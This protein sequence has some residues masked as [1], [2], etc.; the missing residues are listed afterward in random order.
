MLKL[1]RRRDENCSEDEGLDPLS[2]TNDLVRV[3]ESADYCGSLSRHSLLPSHPITSNIAFIASA[4][5]DVPMSAPLIH[6]LFTHRGTNLTSPGESTRIF[7]MEWQN[8]IACFPALFASCKLQARL[9]M[10]Q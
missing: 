4:R 8:E 9:Q 10:V 6:S 5:I 3:S 2:T 1:D 7:H